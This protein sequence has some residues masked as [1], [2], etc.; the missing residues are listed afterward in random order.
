MSVAC[1]STTRRAESDHQEKSTEQNAAKLAVYLLEVTS[2]VVD[3]REGEL[4]LVC[5]GQ[6]LQ[7]TRNALTLGATRLRASR[8][9]RASLT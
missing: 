7:M 4:V 8:R 1:G 6:L 3:G 5:I 2:Q 9:E